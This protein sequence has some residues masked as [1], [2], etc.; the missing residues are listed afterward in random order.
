[1]DV[2]NSHHTSGKAGGLNILAPQR[3][4]K[5]KPKTHAAVT[6]VKAGV[7]SFPR[8]CQSLDSGFHRND[9]L[10]KVLSSNGK[11]LL[12]VIMLKNP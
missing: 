12:L 2:T 8:F 1:M 9:A 5:Q 3:A 6:P 7:Q 10:V 11:H 4:H